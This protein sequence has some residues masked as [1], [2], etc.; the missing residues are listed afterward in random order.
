[1]TV[2]RGIGFGSLAD[3]ATAMELVRFVPQ[4]DI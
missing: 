4:A 3:I 2:T 1:M